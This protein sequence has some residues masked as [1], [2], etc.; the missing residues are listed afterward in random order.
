MKTVR[1]LFVGRF[2]PLH[3]GHLEAI[4]GVLRKVDELIIVIGSSQ[5]SHTLENPFTAGERITMIHLALA[6]AGVDLSSCYTIPVSDVNIHS[7]WV[8]HVI[9]HTP[10]FEVVFTNE[11]LTRRLFKE[12]GFTVKPVPYHHRK[13]YSATEIRNR[14]LKGKLWEELLPKS[15][16]KFTKQI[17]GAKR[18]QELSESDRI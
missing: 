3:K 10:S 5:H 14:M 13:L 12:S 7:I 16:A 6:E 17:N 9:A 4:K 1:G 2:Q 8:A 15:V 11:P 18:L